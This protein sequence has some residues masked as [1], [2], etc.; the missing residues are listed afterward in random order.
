MNHSLTAVDLLE[1]VLLW[2]N[3]NNFDEYD[4]KSTAEIICKLFFGRFVVDS[5]QT[6]N[7]CCSILNVLGHEVR[8]YWEY[9]QC[10]FTTVPIKFDL[11]LATV[12]VVT[13][14]TDLNA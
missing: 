14:L 11:W 9:G 2:C 10:F 1:I 8:R 7:S 3:E 6:E 5:L 13:I 12:V 4:L